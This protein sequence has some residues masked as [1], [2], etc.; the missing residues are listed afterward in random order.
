V[1]AFVR[2]GAGHLR[3]A[4]AVE[5]AAREIAPKATVRKLDIL[6][7]A[8]RKVLQIPPPMIVIRLIIDGSSG[9]RAGN[10]YP[11]NMYRRVVQ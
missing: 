8:E 9:Y 11:C 5:L 7:M 6:E 3:A 1:L 4:E 2:S 10:L